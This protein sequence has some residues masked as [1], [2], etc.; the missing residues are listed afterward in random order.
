L[1]AHE[2]LVAVFPEGAHGVGKPYSERYELQRFGRGGYIKLALR[3][4][5]PIIPTAVIG[6]EDAHPL[7]FPAGAV[8][9][10]L[11]LPFLPITPTFPWLGPLGLVPLPARWVILFGEPM[12]IGPAD[13]ED[14]LA[15]AKLNDEVRAAV[16]ELV[17][18]G[19]ALRRESV[20][21]S[22]PADR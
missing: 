4:G 6:S 11:G 17:R 9:K 18:R 5:A 7:L 13:A 16:G 14:P 15:V 20:G 10:F 21:A 1:L 19:R 12:N 8:S 3:T 2:A 22:M